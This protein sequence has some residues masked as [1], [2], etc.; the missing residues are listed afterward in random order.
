[1][2]TNLRRWAIAIGVAFLGAADDADAQ[3]IGLTDEIVVISKGVGEKH[4]QQNA[5]ALGRAPGA[6]AN[7]FEQ[8]SFGQPGRAEARFRPRG[9]LEAL[10]APGPQIGPASQSLAAVQPRM[11]AAALPPLFGPLELPR[12]EF[13]GPEN[14]LTLDQAI[15]RLVRENYDLRSKYYEIPQARA[16]VLTAGMRANPFY[17]LSASGYPYKPYSPS[18]PGDNGYSVSVVHPFDINHKRQ[19]RAAAATHAVRVLEAQYQNAVR[20]AVDELASAYLDVMV[21]RETL[22]YAEI[23]FAGASRLFDAAEKQFRAGA[24]AEPD[25]LAL[26]I[27]RN[28]ARIGV[29]QAKA[30]HLQAQ[31]TLAALLNIPSGEASSLEL[32]GVIRDNAPP[33]A[34]R[35]ELLSMAL[36][37]RPD[38]AAF[39]FGIRR[40][41]ADV[42][43]A[44]KERIDDVFVIYSPYEFRNN[45]PVGGQNA[46]SYSFGLLGSIPLYDRKQG[47]IRRSELNVAQTRLALAA[48]ERD[49][50]AE[51]ERAEIEYQTSR[52]AVSE[53]ERDVLPS[54]EQ[55]RVAIQ[56]LF[57]TGEKSVVDYLNAQKDHNEIIRQYR[58]AAIRHRRSMLRLN[59][60]VGQRILP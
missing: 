19:A 7:P 48:R 12:G 58:D 18:R 45:G 13:E 11:Q 28:A 22:R 3:I 2:T 24:I 49:V 25:R 33:P 1:M 4:R 6:G 52:E 20:L 9:A 15:E 26:V 47:E 41:Q 16:D 36:A 53:L 27:Q 44:K 55:A 14:G 30:Q 40:S 46:T 34:S 5:G 43:V 54:S 23:S 35:Q 59:T 42:R 8:E 17:F 51:V 39:R 31:H 38:L 29:Q 56:R 57:E 60:A 50:I 32:R 37:G 10:S 21:A